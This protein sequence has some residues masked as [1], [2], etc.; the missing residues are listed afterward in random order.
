MMLEMFFDFTIFKLII[1]PFYWGLLGSKGHRLLPFS[2]GGWVEACIFSFK[3]SWFRIIS[4][5]RIFKR[6]RNPPSVK[7]KTSAILESCKT[8][9]KF[10][11]YS[12]CQTLPLFLNKL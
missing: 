1:D 2:H 8:L 12:F 5:P 4:K 3:Y 10:A 9:Q 7:I 6:K 11:D